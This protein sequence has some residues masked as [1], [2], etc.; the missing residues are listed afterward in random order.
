MTRRDGDTWDPAIGVGMT[1]TFGA[2]ASNKGLIDD[3]C[4][5]PLVRGVG[6]EYFIQVVEHQRYEHGGDD[7]W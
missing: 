1:A 2:V 4:A 7:P 6:V 5:E 3:P